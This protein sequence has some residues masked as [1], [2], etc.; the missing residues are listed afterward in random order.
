MTRIKIF[1]GEIEFDKPAEAAEFWFN[2]MKRM[3]P[4]LEEQCKKI[5]EEYA[6][7][8]IQNQFGNIKSGQA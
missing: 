3:I 4:G 7:T 6:K 8:V 5:G 1:T 2:Y